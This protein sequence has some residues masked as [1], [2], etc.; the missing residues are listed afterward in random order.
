MRAEFCRDARPG[1]EPA[2]VVLHGCGG[3]GGVDRGLAERFPR[4]GYATVYVDYFD[5]TP[6][7]GKR[8]FCSVRIVPR[9]VLSVWRTVVVSAAMALRSRPDVDPRLVGVLGWSMGA[10]VALAAAAWPGAPRFAAV[11]A[12]SPGTVASLTARAV[13]LP[14]TIILM[15]GLGDIRALGGARALAEALRA[16]RISTELYIYPTG[17][18]YWQGRQGEKAFRHAVAFLR[19]YMR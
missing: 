18:H 19:R 12:Y 6:P 17:S 16:A 7:P 15:S 4:A 10:D 8:G 14:P 2:L 1:R 11:V 5:L 13:R 3:F 9:R